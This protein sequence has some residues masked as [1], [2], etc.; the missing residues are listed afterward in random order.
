MYV[1]ESCN[2]LFE[3]PT[4]L[5]AHYKAME[6]GRARA[7][8]LSATM[9]MLGVSH[10]TTIDEEPGSGVEIC[11]HFFRK[12]DVWE[13]VHKMIPPPE[14]LKA[15]VWE[16]EQ[17]TPVGELLTK[18]Q[19]GLLERILSGDQDERDKSRRT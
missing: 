8:E 7:T 1:C 18:R 4:A 2:V 15:V 5:E 16:R 17:D 11:G 12:R 9:D 13:R 3:A 10:L 19:V 14:E 6:W